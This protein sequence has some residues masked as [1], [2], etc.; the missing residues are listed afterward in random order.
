MRETARGEPMPINVHETEDAVV[1][2]ALLPGV[3]PEDVDVHTGD[4]VLTISARST[5]SERDYF[6]Q[7][8]RALEYHRQVALPADLKYDA[9]SAEIEHGML[10]IRVPK[11]KPKRPEKIRVQVS[12]KSTAAAAPIEATKGNGYDE[13]P[14]PKTAGMQPKR[15]RSTPK[16]KS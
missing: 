5:V 13:V 10:V 16:K 15:P 4:G 8:F 14:Q 2:E 3:K 7:E 11:A 6:H 12:R 1:V 9:A